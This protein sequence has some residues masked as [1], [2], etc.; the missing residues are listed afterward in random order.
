M[1]PAPEGTVRGRALGRRRTEGAHI[2]EFLAHL[3]ACGSDLRAGGGLC[4]PRRDRDRCAPAGW[5]RWGRCPAGRR[6]AGLSAGRTGS[7]RYP[8]NGSRPLGMVWAIVSGMHTTPWSSLKSGE[9]V[10]SLGRQVKPAF[11]RYWRGMENINKQ[12]SFSALK[13][14]R[15]FDDTE[16]LK[17]VRAAQLLCILCIFM[18]I[19][20]FSCLYHYIQSTI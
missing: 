12:E 9:C 4:R 5:L 2:I 14:W 18:H 11:P 16:G 6:P 17:D 8:R 15:V 1:K 3:G 10:C 20:P 13:C 7:W 19:Y